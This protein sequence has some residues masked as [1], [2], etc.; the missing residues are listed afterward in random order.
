MAAQELE[1]MFEP[2]EV[3]AQT[4]YTGCAIGRIMERATMHMHPNLALMSRFPHEVK[5]MIKVI[6]WV[7]ICDRRGG[8]VFM[9]IKIARAA[10]PVGSSAS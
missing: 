4:G 2:G 1:R 6:R 10:T 3:S 9:G 7:K 8:A 5:E